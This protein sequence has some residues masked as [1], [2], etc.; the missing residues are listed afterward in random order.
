MTKSRFVQSVCTASML[1]ALAGSNPALAGGPESMDRIPANAAVVLSVK[2]ISEYTKGIESFGSSMSM[3][4]E[5]GDIG[6]SFGEMLS[7]PG[8][9][10]AGSMSVAILP[11]A[12][13]TINMEADGVRWLAIV[14]V[15]DFAAMQKSL[16]EM[17][18]S[19]DPAEDPSTMY[20]KEIGGG[21][22][23]VSDDQSLLELASSG[24]NAT[25]TSMMGSIG[26]SI[27]DSSMGFV[28]VN[29]PL[30]KSVIQEGVGGAKE[31]MAAG[32]MAMGGEA[33][34]KSMEQTFIFMNDFA[35]QAQGA[36]L[37]M[38]F[39]ADGMRMNF[40]AQ[41]KEGT[42]MAGYFAEGGDS[43]SLMSKLPDQDFLIAGAFDTSS[44]GV[45]LAMKKMGEFSKGM[46]DAAQQMAAASGMPGDDMGDLTKMMDL[47]GD[48]ENL[49]GT[50]FCIGSAP[51]GIMGG[52]FTNAS[53]YQKT[54]KA[55]ELRQASRA[56]IEQMNGKSIMGMKVTSEY[57]AAAATIAGVEVDS[58]S[59]AMMPDPNDPNG[60]Q[61]QMM[62]NMVFG[63]GG[64]G[65]M[66]AVIG[67]GLVGTMSQNTKLMGK[68]IAAAKGD[69][70]FA[71]NADIASISGKL[72]AK[73]IFEMYI[74]SKAIMENIAG[75]AMMAGGEA[76]IQ[77]P[78]D[79]QPVALAATAGKG[80]MGMHLFVPA[81]FMKAVESLSE[82]A[83]PGMEEPMDDMGG[84]DAGNPRF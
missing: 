30:F 52:L 42:E 37:G 15:S 69:G 79:L 55:A 8:L 20:S 26:D 1:V 22:A 56:M 31:E 11:G 80:G 67:D 32:P 29:M 27:S 5:M 47:I 7:M 38:D 18:A 14:P 84:D 81:S 50:A 16:S 72:P 61:A 39:A 3:M 46:Q 25:F 58:W 66:S 68:A 43:A 34:L 62:M 23:A 19:A 77:V 2:N 60:M 51:G 4:E 13:G 74:G 65:G 82:M 9:N 57:S 33:M 70:G 21:F 10:T 6:A 48:Y 64:M 71:A 40:G 17:G 59:T 53:T 35:D 78:K 75:F 49:D 83:G 28:F 54:S 36:V 76:E 24:S 12:D 41:F 44:P 73:R 63:A 45:R